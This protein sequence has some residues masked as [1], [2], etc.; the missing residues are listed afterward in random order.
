MQWLDRGDDI[1]RGEAGDV[2]GAHHLKMLDPV[3]AVAGAV[4]LAR[5]FI[6]IQRLPDRS[7]ADGVG[8]RFAGQR[9]RRGCTLL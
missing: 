7:V 1:Q 5:F 8:P 9:H 6:A 2:I 3:A 4:H